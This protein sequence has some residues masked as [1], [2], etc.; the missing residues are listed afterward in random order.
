LLERLTLDEDPEKLI[1]PIIAATADNGRAEI[2]RGQ[3]ERLAG[4]KRLELFEDTPTHE[5]ID[6]RSIRDSGITWRFLAG[7]PAHVVQREAGHEAGYALTSSGP[8]EV[9][10]QRPSTKTSSR[11]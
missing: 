3:L 8:G 10:D 11:L 7:H 1:A 5:R 4:V 6:F 9:S 2:F